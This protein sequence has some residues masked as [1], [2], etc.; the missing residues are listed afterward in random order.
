MTISYTYIFFVSLKF[1]AFIVKNATLSLHLVFF[2]IFW[3][4]SPKKIVLLSFS[5]LFLMK[6][7]ISATEY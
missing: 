2:G 6:Y 3:F 5:F 7:Q 4:I 1:G